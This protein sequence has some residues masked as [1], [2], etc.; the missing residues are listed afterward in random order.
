M[1]IA[2]AVSVRLWK[3]AGYLSTT[4]RM[5]DSWA[6]QTHFPQNTFGDLTQ[7]KPFPTTVQLPPDEV[8]RKKL[9]AAQV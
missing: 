7:T 3:L 6:L 5:R 9:S 1:V 4:V 8:D 2:R